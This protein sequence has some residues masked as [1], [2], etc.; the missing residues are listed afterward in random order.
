LVLDEKI[1]LDKFKSLWT[2]KR[3]TI[4][5]NAAKLSLANNIFDKNSNEWYWFNTFNIDT[6]HIYENQDGMMV[7]FENDS[8]INIGKEYTVNKDH[9]L[10]FAWGK[11]DDSLFVYKI[12]SVLANIE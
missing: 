2:K 7:L 6:Y 9:T 11:D 4:T 8:V 12:E 3:H 10:L 5:A 1:V